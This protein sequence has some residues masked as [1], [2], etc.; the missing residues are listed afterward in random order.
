MGR[1]A[2]EGDVSEGKSGTWARAH[3]AH[4][5]LC[6]VAVSVWRKGSLF[7]TNTKGSLW[8]SWGSSRETGTALELGA[9]WGGDEN[10]QKT[11]VQGVGKKQRGDQESRRL[12]KMLPLGVFGEH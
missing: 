7:L 11:R 8:V 6:L 12:G 9:Q 1:E 4:Q 3:S 10:T 5:A 2:G